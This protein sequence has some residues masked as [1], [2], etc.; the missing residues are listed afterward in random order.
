[1]LDL[2]RPV[3]RLRP[4]PAVVLIHGGGMW[5]G[6]RADM[7]GPAGQLAEAGYVALAI[8]YR[9]VDAAAGRHRWPAQLDDVQLAVRWVRAN[10]ARLGVDPDRLAAYGWSAGGQ[11]AALLGTRDTRDPTLGLAALSS[12]V[13]SV[14]VLAGDVDL[15]A[16]TQPPA[17]DEVAALLGGTPDEV[18]EL[19]RDSSPL[20]W[21]DRRSAPFL[22]VHGTRDRVV[23]LA[24]SRRLVT[25]LR[26]AG[27]ETSYLELADAGHDDLG[28]SRVGPAVLAFLDH[29]LRPGT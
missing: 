9:L 16:Y 28:W 18:L 1:M 25:A 29:H 2:Y 15:A 17:S 11:L 19:Y 3:E 5:T 14:V 4:R 21:I 26:R 13:A 24:Q 23:P 6:S 7:A 10:A 20:S 8:D 22:V 27:I 12:R